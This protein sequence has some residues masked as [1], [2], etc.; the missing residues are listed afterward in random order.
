[1]TAYTCGITGATGGSLGQTYGYVYDDTN[2]TMSSMTVSASGISDTLSFT[3]DPLQRLT[4]KNTV[5]TG[6]TLAQEYSYKTV[7]GNRTSTL[8]SGVTQK[9]N[10]T[11]VDSYTYTY[12]SLGNI[13]AINRSGYE[14]LSYTYDTQNQLIK[15]VEGDFRHE[16]AYDTYGNLLSVKTYDNEE[17]TAITKKIRTNY[18]SPAVKR[19]T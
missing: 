9:V 19:R 4:A 15:V 16:Y 13:T 8:I 18:S 5:R 12:D 1:M 10:G 11:T 17:L 7:S 14:P 6:L 3:Y 2:G